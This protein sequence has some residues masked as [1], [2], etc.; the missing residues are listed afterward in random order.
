MGVLQEG[1]GNTGSCSN[2]GSEQYES[3]I[4]IV[5]LLSV[6]IHFESV[7][8]KN[9]DI[10]PWLLN[11]NLSRAFLPIWWM[12]VKVVLSIILHMNIWG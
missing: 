10:L 8:P 4:K 11:D 5:G 1:S 3:H 6:A 2:C 12:V 7:D 9:F